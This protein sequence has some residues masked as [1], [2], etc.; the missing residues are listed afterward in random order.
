MNKVKELIK[1]ETLLFDG[2]MGT[3]FSVK[4]HLPGFG[5]E[6]V[7]LSQPVLIGA[8][9]REYMEAGS[10][11]IKTNTFAANRVIFQH[12]GEMVK[13]IIR[14][15]MR[16][17]VKAAEP[18][19][20]AVFADIGPVVGLYRKETIEEFKFIAGEFIKQGAENFLFETLSDNDGIQEVAEFIREQVEDPFIIASFALL[21]EGYTRDGRFG[22]DLL[23]NTWETG[24]FDA[25]GLNCICGVRQ[26]K[27]LMDR[28]DLD[29]IRLSVM[30]NSGYPIVIDNRT[31]YDSD[32]IYFGKGLARLAG[33]GIPIIGGCCG[34][35]PRHIEAAKNLLDQPVDK[36]KKKTAKVFKPL[37][38]S[39]SSPFWD[40]LA[41]GGKVIAV[42]LDPPENADLQRYLEN[43]QEI[44]ES[45][46]DIMTIADCP[47]ARARM[48]SSLLACIVKDRIGLET[49][50]HLT[51]RDR[52]LNA[53]KALLLG[54]SADGVRNVLVVTGDPIPTAERDEVKSVYQFNSRKM[55]A[56]IHSLGRTTLPQ[57]FHIFGAL[58][59][60][61]INFDVQL[62]IAKEKVENGMAGMLTQPVLTEK[63]LENLKRARRELDCYILGGIIPIVS[64]KNARFMENEITGINISPEIIE[65]YVGLDREESEDLAVR[66]SSE[67]AEKMK[68]Y[69]DGYYLITPFS[70]TGLIR[71]IIAEIKAHQ[72]PG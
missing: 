62:S 37:Q 66:L 64:E 10:R 72:N 15:G 63:G 24:C 57:P 60:N 31:F 33:Y 47:V 49:I 34:T 5:C 50:P 42:E 59:I 56:F 54:L 29:G 27:K 8:I 55:A 12:D 11:A 58:N 40:K 25:V 6:L 16:I 32:P 28:M 53:T 4:E 70:R 26:M 68:P 67:I 36:K 48:D 39:V 46:A 21:P 1:N 44:Q 13:R 30:P 2:G 71:R 3:Y 35:T 65:S 9:H 17:A 52:N 19:G 38:F 69:V 41:T 45:G 23:R 18:F 51:C 14:S 22:E 20:A 7:N 43:A 61:A